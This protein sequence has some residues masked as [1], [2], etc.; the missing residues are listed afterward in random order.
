LAL[1]TAIF[2]RPSPIGRSGK[3]CAARHRQKAAQ[4]PNSETAICANRILSIDITGK[5]KQTADARPHRAGR[6]VRRG[7]SANGGF[8]ANVNAAASGCTPTPM[9]VE[10]DDDDVSMHYLK[11]IERIARRSTAEG[12]LLQVRA[13][14]VLHAR[15]AVRLPGG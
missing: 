5:F 8:V 7:G 4:P 10:A 12:N 11:T 3:Q 2:I 14:C 9:C 6:N 1:N 15:G 13:V